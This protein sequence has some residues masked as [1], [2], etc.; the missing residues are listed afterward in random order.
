MTKPNGAYPI[1]LIGFF[2]SEIGLGQA[3]RNMAHA[4]SDAGIPVNHI[5]ID[6]P[7][8]SSDTEFLSRCVPWVPGVNN[9]LVSDILNMAALFEGFKTEG[10]GRREILYPFW[11]LTNVPSI[12]IK[13]LDLYEEIFAPSQFVAD[14]FS[15]YRSKTVSVIPQPVLISNQVVPNVLSGDRLKIFSFFDTDSY[16]SRKNPKEILDAFQRAFPKNIADVELVLKLRGRRDDGVRKI[17]LDYALR[18]YRVKI[19]DRTLDR[20]SMDELIQSC[21]VF[22][23]LHRSE[24]FGLGPA[25]ALCRE[26]IVI[27][28]D[29]GGTCDFINPN[30]GYP[31]GFK[32]I[33]LKESDYPFSQN[34][35]WADPFVDEAAMHLRYVY[36]NFDAAKNKGIEGRKLMIAQHSYKAV[37]QIVKSIFKERG[38]L[39]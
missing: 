27:S 13:M 1:S 18:D 21:N 37:G 35:V 26:K 19:I 20:V 25:E 38:Y 31:V 14:T 22:V 6:L 11:E 30:T 7:S 33:D 28:T 3:V 10:K 15:Q 8:V 39:Q 16:P 2:L 34:Q 5:N 12:V 23:S 17:L 29:Y 36:E 32:L 24:G 4:F 9:F